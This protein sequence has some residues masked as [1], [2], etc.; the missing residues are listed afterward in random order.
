MTGGERKVTD[1]QDCLVVTDVK[2]HLTFVV[3]TGLQHYT[4]Y[5]ACG[6]TAIPLDPTL[7]WLAPTLH[8][9]Y[10]STRLIS[11]RAKPQKHVSRFF[12]GEQED[13]SPWS[14]Q[15]GEEGAGEGGERETDPPQRGGTCSLRHYRREQQQ[16]NN[17]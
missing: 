7:I 6:Y 13:V 12:P 10:P 17:G 14:E 8:K 1:N 5:S 9:R 15:A 16:P 4:H 11:S 2:P 3:T